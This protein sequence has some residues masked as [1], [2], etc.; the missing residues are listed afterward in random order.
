MAESQQ[1][2]AKVILER[3][4]GG[5]SILVYWRGWDQHHDQQRKT[6]DQ[7]ETAGGAKDQRVAT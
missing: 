1:E 6:F 7:F 2:I 5:E 3:S 4:G